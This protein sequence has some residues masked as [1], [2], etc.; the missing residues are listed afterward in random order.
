MNSVHLFIDV[1]CSNGVKKKI[2]IAPLLGADFRVEEL[3]YSNIA[4]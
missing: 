1:Y 2:D 3:K 4:I